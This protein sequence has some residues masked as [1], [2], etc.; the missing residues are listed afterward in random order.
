[1]LKKGENNNDSR[2]EVLNELFEENTTNFLEGNNGDERVF[3]E[4]PHVG[5]DK[6]NVRLIIK[7]QKED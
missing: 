6:E 5:H 7:R 2:F 3:I 1:M 4:E